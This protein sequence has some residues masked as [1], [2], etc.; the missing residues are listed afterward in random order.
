MRLVQSVKS[1][2]KFFLNAFF[3]REKLNVI[4]QQHFTLTVF[5]AERHQLVVLNRLDVFVRKFFR[6]HIRNARAF[7]IARDVL[8]DGLQ[9]MRFAQTDATVKK[10]WIVNFAR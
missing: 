4:N 9:Q 3:A 7:F 2:K 5:F 6:R 8:A 10:Q 1:V